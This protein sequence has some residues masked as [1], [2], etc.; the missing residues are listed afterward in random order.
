MHSI[1]VC[2][3]VVDFEIIGDFFEM[4]LLDFEMA[5]VEVFFRRGIWVCVCVDGG[6][7]G[8]ENVGDSENNGRILK[9]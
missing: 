6:E 7:F 9:C 8:G 4:K 5:D 2:L 1:F 3:S